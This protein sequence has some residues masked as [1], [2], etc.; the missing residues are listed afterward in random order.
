MCFSRFYVVAFKYIIVIIL[1]S[2]LDLE[3]T[4]IKVVYIFFDLK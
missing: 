3:I 1:I 4:E 2:V